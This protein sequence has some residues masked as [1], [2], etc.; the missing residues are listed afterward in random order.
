MT[1]LPNLPCLC[2]SLRRASRALT[3][4]YEEALRPRGLRATQ[5]TILQALSIA[6]ELTQ[7]D[8]GEILAT[9]STTL[10][11]TLDI[12]LRHGWLS[13][14]RGHDRREWRLRLDKKGAA[15][16]RR[17]LPDWEAVQA[18]VRRRLGDTNW[19]GLHTLVDVV[20]NEL[21]K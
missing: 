11:R 13:R 7:G 17:A 18:R 8:L 19:D 15:L 21:R 2:A 9:D 4:M 20:S 3:Q 14:Q 12:M 1:S 5:F 6:G 16:F 10:T